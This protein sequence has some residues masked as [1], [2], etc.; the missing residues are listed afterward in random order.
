VPLREEN[1]E[2]KMTRTHGRSSVLHGRKRD[3]G[4]AK[5]TGAPVGRD[6][7]L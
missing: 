5:M 7:A 3:I 6:R 4:V 1:V 2:M